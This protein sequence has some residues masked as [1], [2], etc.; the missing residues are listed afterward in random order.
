MVGKLPSIEKVAVVVVDVVVVVPVVLEGGVD[1]VS[2]SP[3]VVVLIV[4]VSDP[5]VTVEVVIMS[6]DVV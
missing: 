2:V 6:V 5:S 1:G 3:K 4:V